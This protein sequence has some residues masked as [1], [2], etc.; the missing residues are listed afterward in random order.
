MLED[1]SL[2]VATCTLYHSI[3][4]YSIVSIAIITKC[5][6][7]LLCQPVDTHMLEGAL[8]VPAKVNS[9]LGRLNSH[10]K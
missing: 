4:L 10:C 3:L 8:K 9:K 5:I 1:P 6:L 7:L 2:E